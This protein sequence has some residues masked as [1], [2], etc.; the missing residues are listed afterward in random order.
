[1]SRIFLTVTFCLG[2]AAAQAGPYDGLYRP[3]GDFG[4]A[5]TCTDVG[6]DGGALAIEGDL[7]TGVENQCRLTDPVAIRETSATRYTA[8]CTGEGETYERPFL[9]FLTDNGVGILDDY[10]FAQ[11]DRCQ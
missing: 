5:W 3:S 7:W 11:F 8:I 9:I 4:Q 1:M 10:G 6:M 2:A